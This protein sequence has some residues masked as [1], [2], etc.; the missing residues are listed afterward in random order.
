MHENLAMQGRQNANDYQTL[1][2]RLHQFQ[3]QRNID[4][5][6]SI[7]Y[8][9]TRAR[10][11]V[12]LAITSGLIVVLAWTLSSSMH[13]FPN[14]SFC[15]CFSGGLRTMLLMT[16]L[17]V[18]AIS[19]KQAETD[20][21]VVVI[22]PQNAAFLTAQDVYRL[23][24]GKVSSFPDGS[25]AVP[26]IHYNDKDQLQAFS[27]NVLGRSTRQLRSYWARQLFTGK[28]KPPLEVESVEKMKTLITSNP[29]Y[30]G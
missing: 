7:N 3:A 10:E 14:N 28:G 27:A 9:T 23:Y 29:N 13:I 20:S 17:A 24:F 19:G 12:S 4:F 25:V 16:V 21:L 6:R 22:H 2:A 11:T 1:M 18:M 5:T 8:T 30:V 15:G 26:V